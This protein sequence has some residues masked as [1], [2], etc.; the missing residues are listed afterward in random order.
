MAAPCPPIIG[1]LTGA[2]LALGFVALSALGGRD[3]PALPTPPPNQTLAQ[4][5]RILPN[6]PAWQAWLTRS[7]EAPPLFAELPNAALR[8][9]PVVPDRDTETISLERSSRALP[10]RPALTDTRVGEFPFSLDPEHLATW[11]QETLAAF[12]HYVFGSRPKE[13]PSWRVETLDQ[14]D[15]HPPTNERLRLRIGPPQEIW[16]DLELRKPPQASAARTVIWCGDT[17]PP[18]AILRNGHPVCRILAVA[19][20]HGPPWWI[21]ESWAGQ[22]GGRLAREAW[23]VSIVAD[24]LRSRRDRSNAPGVVVAGEAWG[25]K[26]ALWAAAAHPQIDA[27][28]AA[29]SGPGGACPFRLWTEAEFGNGIELLTRQHPEWFHPRLR[30]FVGREAYLPVDAADLLALIAPRPCLVASA[31]TNPAESAWAVEQAWRAAAPVYESYGECDA[32][33]LDLRLGSKPPREED[34]QR[35]LAW[36][37]DHLDET[38]TTTP[39][40]PQPR[41][42]K[43]ISGPLFPDG[44]AILPADL[45][46]NETE[47]TPFAPTFGL[48]EDDHGN[49]IETPSAWMAKRAARREIIQAQLGPAA[50]PTDTP[51]RSRPP[52]VAPAERGTIPEWLQRETLLIHGGLEGVLLYRTNIV[53]T[54]RR[55][56]AIIW[57]HPWSVPTG[58]AAAATRAEQPWLALARSGSVILAFDQIGCGTRVEESFPF[59]RRHPDRSLLGQ[60]VSD[61][62]AAITALRTHPHVDPDQVFLLGAGLGGAVALHVAALD[63][64]VG[65]VICV[66]GFSPLRSG[67]APDGGSLARWTKHP[68]L[69]PKLAAY[70]GNESLL[71]YDFDELLAMVAPRPCLVVAATVDPGRSLPDIRTSVEAARSV[72]AL[73]GAPQALVLEVKDDYV[74]FTPDSLWCL[75]NDPAQR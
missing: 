50:P 55:L 5:E 7:Q 26:V 12:D 10:L 21:G 69:L 3:G 27:V 16:L 41:Q 35:W 38:P 24:W 60:M 14:P 49:P 65:G 56:P 13:P 70:A 47:S 36:L 54:T 28:L 75:C 20:D 48:L 23:C 73:L 66:N 52:E 22:E 1:N 64:R 31:I 63:D 68:P 6:S 8:P 43:A 34:W 33:G 11:R 44:Q 17:E 4:L 53:G 18:E 29:D 32:F 37:D 62:R 59:Y 25:G 51:F 72:Y 19:G 30:F 58:Y 74:H 15:S 9:E 67:A 42:R 71:P 40:S 57:L 39:A 61:T 46:A 2:C 45:A